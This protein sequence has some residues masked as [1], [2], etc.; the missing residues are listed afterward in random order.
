MNTKHTP[1]PWTVKRTRDHDAA[2]RV[3]DCQ[4]V[5]VA[6][7]YQQPHDTWR[8]KDNA[9]VIAAALDLLAAVEMVLDADGDLYAIDF[10]RLRAAIAKAKG[11]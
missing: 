11:E 8:A 1:G 5:T 9:D 6:L 10:D 3:M 2:Y 4:E 7:C